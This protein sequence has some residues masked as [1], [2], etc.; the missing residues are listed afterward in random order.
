V[1]ALQ[2]AAGQQKVQLL[3][4]VL[5]S[6]ILSSSVSSPAHFENEVLTDRPFWDGFTA[7]YE[8]VCCNRTQLEHCGFSPGHRVFFR[9]AEAVSPN[10]SSS[11]IPALRLKRQ[12]T[13][14]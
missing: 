10:S 1:V 5:E 11:L 9:L 8:H 2:A 3:L 6:L 4:Q 7:G 13:C 12:L 14:S